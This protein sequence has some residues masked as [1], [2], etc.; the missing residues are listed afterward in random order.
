MA[1]PPIPVAP[2]M[3]PVTLDFTPGTPPVFT[4][5]GCMEDDKLTVAQALGMIVIQLQ[6]SGATFG[7]SPIVWADEVPTCMSVHR[8]SDAQVTIVNWNSNRDEP[9]AYNFQV[10]VWYEGSSY[11]SHDPTIINATIP[12]PLPH[13][14]E[15]GGEHR[16]RVKAAAA[17]LRAV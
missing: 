9:Y 10:I 13:C 5:G 17:A 14:G 12:T 1:K 16:P 15:E 3:Y 11:M 4:F 2:M 8:D 6:T 7:P